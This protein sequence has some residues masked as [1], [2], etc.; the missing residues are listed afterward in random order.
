MPSGNVVL[1]ASL[2][3]KVKIAVSAL[4]VQSMCEITV[5]NLSAQYRVGESAAGR[6][7]RTNPDA[8]NPAKLC[9]RG[10]DGGL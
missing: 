1:D 4:A 9:Q 7:E 2:D 6:S 3:M 5:T 10:R 8:G